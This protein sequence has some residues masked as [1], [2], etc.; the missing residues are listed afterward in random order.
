MIV[1][2]ERENYEGDIAIDDLS[3][4]GCRS[5]E[6]GF[7]RPGELTTTALPTTRMTT[8]P[9]TQAGESASLP[10]SLPGVLRRVMINKYLK[11]GVNDMCSIS[12]PCHGV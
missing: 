11:E 12:L 6:A 4:V 5:D 7:G 9:T 3:L 1:E 2:A 10:P 8:K